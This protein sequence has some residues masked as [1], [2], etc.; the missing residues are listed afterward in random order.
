MWLELI[1]NFIFLMECNPIENNGCINLCVVDNSM[2]LENNIRQ[3][4]D[5]PQQ[6]SQVF[7]FYKQS[8]NSES[9]TEAISKSFR[10]LL[11]NEPHSQDTI[12]SEKF[13]FETS[14]YSPGPQSYFP[15]FSPIH[16]NKS[17]SVKRGYACDETVNFQYNGGNITG[18]Y[19]KYSKHDQHHTNVSEE[20][21]PSNFIPLS[22]SRDSPEENSLVNIF[23]LQQ[24][25]CNLKSNPM[26]IKS[27]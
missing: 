15:P 23:N 13:E 14:E 9:V 26:P 19:P 27:F 1:N 25:P 17:S 22:P 20:L 6:E 2:L 12:G 5:L 18:P 21:I 10:I 4:Q 24:T 11:D 3:F 16:S 8:V 7:T